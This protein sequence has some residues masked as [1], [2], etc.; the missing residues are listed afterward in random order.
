M[1]GE[2]ESG[3]A[4]YSLHEL[5]TSGTGATRPKWGEDMTS[6]ETKTFGLGEISLSNILGG[7][8]LLCGALLGYTHIAAG[9]DRATLF[10]PASGAEALKLLP[11]TGLAAAGLLQ[12]VMLAPASAWSAFLHFLL[13][14]WP[15]SMI[16]LGAGLLRKNLFVAGQAQGGHTADACDASASD[17][18]A[19]GVRA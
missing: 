4:G 6:L 16:F 13:S 18:G 7:G 10:L 5:R 2:A 12:E 14:C 3:K 8:L 19:R 11:G 17:G 9:L 1:A 15:V